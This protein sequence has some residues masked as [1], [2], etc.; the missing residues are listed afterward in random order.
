[1][2]GCRN[3]TLAALLA[4]YALVPSSAATEDAVSTTDRLG[5]S[6]EFPVGAK[7]V[8]ADFMPLP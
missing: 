5:R 7:R 1:M 4:G 2:P 6:V 3:P 8:P